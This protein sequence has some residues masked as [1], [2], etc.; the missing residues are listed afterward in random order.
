MPGDEEEEQGSEM[1]P[2][3]TPPGNQEVPTKAKATAFIESKFFA[4]AISLASL[5]LVVLHTAWSCH[6]DKEADAFTVGWDVGR[7]AT[8]LESLNEIK[9]EL[10]QCQNRVELLGDGLKA[11]DEEIQ[12]YRLVLHT[13][14]PSLVEDILEP[15][16]T[17]KDA[18][19]K[20]SGEVAQLVCTQTSN[21]LKPVSSPFL[22]GT[23]IV[24]ASP[25]S[26][27][28][29]LSDATR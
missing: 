25:E 20:W 19:D 5:V 29:R 27:R 4:H 3:G 7:L 11:L 28:R 22:R 23:C 18:I 10:G 15:E 12:T 2:S 6:R 26:T 1:S 21:T 24:S 14:L 17:V 16:N 13:K 9:E 8:G